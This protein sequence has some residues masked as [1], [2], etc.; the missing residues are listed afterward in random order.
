VEFRLHIRAQCTHTG[1]TP[2]APCTDDWN[3]RHGCECHRELPSDRSDYAANNTLRTEARQ[4]YSQTGGSQRAR[5]QSCCCYKSKTP[6]SPPVTATSDITDKKT[7]RLYT[8]PAATASKHD[9]PLQ[10]S[11]SHIHGPLTTPLMTNDD[12]LVAWH[13]GRT[14]VS[15]RR[16]FP[17]PRST[18]SWWVTTIVGKPSA[19]GQPTRPT[20]P[21]ILY[22]SINE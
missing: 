7:T 1:P 3:H 16:T 12:Q 20:Q 4:S 19:K 10:T 6:A 9:I 22:G 21:F 8:R 2:L 17:D 14:S 13:S 15:G 11:T 5:K 18:C